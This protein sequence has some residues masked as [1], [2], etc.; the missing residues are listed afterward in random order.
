MK[1]VIPGG[2]GHV[3]TVLARA[4]HRDGHEVV[5]L[6]RR[7]AAAPWHVISWDGVT[8]GDWSKELDG[9]DVVINL[10]G[11]SVNCRYT[12]A[13]RKAILDSRVL[14][15]RV[16]GQAIALARRPPRVWLQASTAT[17]Y[18][19][20]YDQANDE[21]SGVLGGGERDAPDT[22]K[23]S[24]D[25]ARAWELAFDQS[26]VPSR[27]VKLRSA[28]TMSPGAGGPF[29]ALLG[30]VRCGLGGSAGDG[31]QYV[32][33]VHD[34]DFVE[35]VR[36]LIAARR[37]RRRRQRGGAKSPA[38]RRVHASVAAGCGR[39][40]RSAGEQVDAGNRRCLHEDRDRAHSQ[41]PPR[42]APQAARSRLRLQ[43]S[44][45]ARCGR[46]S[47]RP[48]EADAPGRIESGV[49]G[50]STQPAVGGSCE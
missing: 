24:I 1:I 39:S 14:S 23:F 49:M 9:C 3:G 28:I 30:L 5:V 41:E 17:I 43:V 18:S 4:F 13:N 27:K 26:A 19:H 15:T 21:A 29:D 38:E 47:L 40:R 48:M 37:G 22:W 6:S 10:A 8:I 36:W 12:A 46:R 32:S 44:D 45:L 11:R 34:E 50:L 35:A 25:V 42:R 31:R 20:R 2:S 16:V 7:P 33:W